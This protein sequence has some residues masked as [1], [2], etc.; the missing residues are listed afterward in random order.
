M[1]HLAKKTIAPSQ[2]ILLCFSRPRDHIAREFGR[3]K[4]IVRIDYYY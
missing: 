4:S 2:P 3:I 1:T